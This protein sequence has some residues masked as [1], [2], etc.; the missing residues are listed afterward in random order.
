MY[1]ELDLAFE[2][3]KI[4]IETYLMHKTI[5]KTKGIWFTDKFLTMAKRDGME[6]LYCTDSAR[7]SV[8]NYDESVSSGTSLISTYNDNITS[9]MYTKNCSNVSVYKNCDSSLSYNIDQYFYPNTEENIFQNSL[10]LDD[11]SNKCIYLYNKLKE[12]IDSSSIRTNTFSVSVLNYNTEDVFYYTEIERIH[13]MYK[14][15]LC[16]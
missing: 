15:L 8:L 13:T 12:Y 11:T 5:L 3:V 9:I 7:I 2:R 14:E 10:I 16:Y 1:N 6:H 4:F